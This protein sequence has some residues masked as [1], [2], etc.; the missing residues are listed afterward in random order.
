ME[1]SPAIADFPK[2]YKPPFMGV[3]NCHIL[4]PDGNSF[5]WEHQFYIARFS[6]LRCRDL[7]HYKRIRRIT[8]I[9]DSLLTYFLLEIRVLLNYPLVNVYITME[10]HH[11]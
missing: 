9:T 6:S 7:Q 4:L 8:V 10:N 3:S 11:F 2:N 1:N 5:Q